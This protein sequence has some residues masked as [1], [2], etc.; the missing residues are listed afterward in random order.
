MR[1]ITGI[2]AAVVFCVVSAAVLPARAE[3]QYS[4]REE[5]KNIVVEIDYGGLRS[6]RSIEIP[7]VKGKTVLEVLQTVAAVETHTVGQY[8]FVTSIDGVQGKYGDMAW[9]YT[10][11]D[12]SPE[13]LAYSKVLNGTEHVKWI[14]KKDVYS[15]KIDNKLNPQG[16][17]GDQK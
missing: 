6:S 15:W 10:I 12:K 8:V 1:R 11:D 7:L 13:E 14:Y 5:T 9:Y 16:K 2:I 4:G 3:N 17:G